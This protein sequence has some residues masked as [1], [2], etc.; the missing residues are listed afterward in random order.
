MGFTAGQ[1]HKMTARPM[2]CP[3]AFASLT[4][5][6]AYTLDPIDGQRL[7]IDPGGSTR[8]VTLGEDY[9]QDGSWV[10][11]VNTASGAE[12]LTI[13]DPAGNTIVT[14]SQNEKAVVAYNGSAYVHQ[15]IVAIALT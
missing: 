8:V 9:G 4:L 11:I 14:I 2:F 1:I 13:N 7:R 15:G 3:G 5:S 12:D 10:E 6:G